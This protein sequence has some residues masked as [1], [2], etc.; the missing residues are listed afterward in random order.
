MRLWGRVARMLVALALLLAM[1]LTLP[2]GAGAGHA[3]A[4]PHADAAASGPCHGA[5]SEAPAP[6]PARPNPTGTID[7]CLGGGCPP[8]LAALPTVAEPSTRQRHRLAP[9]VPGGSLLDGCS[10]APTL[11]PPRV[12]A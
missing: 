3:A 7:G 4:P 11:P 12:A 6:D 8:P 10:I 2:G 9:L 1:P 5:A